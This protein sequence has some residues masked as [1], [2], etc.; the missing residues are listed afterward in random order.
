MKAIS[1]EEMGELRAIWKEEKGNL[2]H[3]KDLILEMVGIS[4][5]EHH[6]Q[7]NE[8]I[9]LYG[10]DRGYEQ[11]FGWLILIAPGVILFDASED[12]Y[13]SPLSGLVERRKEDRRFPLLTVRSFSP[14]WYNH[15]LDIYDQESRPFHGFPDCPVYVNF[16]MGAGMAESY[17]YLGISKERWEVMSR[18]FD[19]WLP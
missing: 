18:W 5:V 8:R 1:E 17:G 3:I 19:K 2:K 7:Y 11:L 14:H 13:F 4:F 10:S 6:R 15:S 16:Q 9:L 12:N